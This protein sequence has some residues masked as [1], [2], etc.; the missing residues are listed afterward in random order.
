MGQLDAWT[1]QEADRLSNIMVNDPHFAAN[2]MRNEIQQLQQM[3]PN[4]QQ[5]ISALIG[6]T[7]NDE[8][9]GGMG[10]LQIQVERDQQHNAYLM[11]KPAMTKT[12]ATAST[13]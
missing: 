10:D 2:E 6:K 11:A 13:H 5:T 3:G 7:K 8:Y 12:M 9:V 1:D 4:G